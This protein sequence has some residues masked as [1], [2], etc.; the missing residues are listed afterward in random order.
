[1]RGGKVPDTHF[2]QKLHF[3][4]SHFH[5]ESALGHDFIDANAN[6]NIR[7]VLYRVIHP[8]LG[9][10]KYGGKREKRKVV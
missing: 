7:L 2:A 5:G 8:N 6:P 9:F 1:M 10:T 3:V 4:A